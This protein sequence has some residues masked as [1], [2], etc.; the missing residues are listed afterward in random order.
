MQMPNLYSAQQAQE[1]YQDLHIFFKVADCII[2]LI[3]NFL[4]CNDNPIL[5]VQYWR[6]R[7]LNLLGPF[8]IHKFAISRIR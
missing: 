7:F 3:K 8:F 5:S 2:S 1:E 4:P 6:A